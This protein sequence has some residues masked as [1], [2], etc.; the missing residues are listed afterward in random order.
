[1]KR[2]EC[3][4]IVLEES[5]FG[6]LQFQPTWIYVGKGQRAVT[7]SPSPFATLTNRVDLP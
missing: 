3:P 6:D 2:R 5:G 7:F 1:M 4:F